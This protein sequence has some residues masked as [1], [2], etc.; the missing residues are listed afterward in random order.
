MPNRYATTAEL[1]ANTAQY[2]VAGDPDKY[3]QLI[4]LSQMTTNSEDNKML[5]KMTQGEVY[6]SPSEQNKLWTINSPSQL[7][8][9]LASKREKIMAKDFCSKRKTTDD[10]NRPADINSILYYN[11]PGDDPII[12]IDRENRVSRSA[13]DEDYAFPSSIP[14][15][16]RL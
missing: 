1:N 10:W 13:Y 7:Q 16:L 6:L 5:I 11:C 3:N 15:G 12:S 14:L 8:E 9:M 4:K 2:L